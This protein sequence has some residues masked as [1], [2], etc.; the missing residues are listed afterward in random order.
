MARLLI[1]LASYQGLAFLEQQL[2]SICRQTYRDW[3][4]LVRNDG[5]DPDTAA[6]VARYAAQDP[7]I[8]WLAEPNPQ[9]LGVC[10]NFACLLEQALHG[11]YDY[12]A[13]ADQDD[14]WQAQKL[15]QQLEQL[16][17]TEQRLG[18]TTPILVHSDL[19]LVDAQLK[20]LASSFMQQRGL[21]PAPNLATLLAQNSVTGCTCV[22]NR[23]LLQLALP[24]PATI[25]MH[26]WWLALCA[27]AAGQLVYWPHATVAYRQHSQNSV[28]AELKLS[29]IRKLIYRS[30]KTFLSSFMQAALLRD[31]LAD[32]I[33]ARTI[34][35]HYAELPNINRRQR[36]RCYQQLQIQRAGWLAGWLYRLR[37]LL[38]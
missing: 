36:Y 33:P 5:P 21:N 19:Q 18:R 16:Q 20:P 23:A 22:G 11:G 34:L 17:S 37:L 38:L 8:Q 25:A 7:R 2:Q 28:G 24:L 12:F 35:Q 30:R 9:R 4:L 1:V 31:R 32:T 3:H 10:A 15:E 13:L 26:D 27:Q 29:K 14:V 6:L